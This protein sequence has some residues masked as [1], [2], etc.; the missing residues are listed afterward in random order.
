MWL[1]GPDGGAQRKGSVDLERKCSDI[2]SEIQ[3]LN[4]RQEIYQGAI[5]GNLRVQDRESKRLQD[6]IIEE[7]RDLESTQTE[8]ALQTVEKEHDLWK[9]KQTHEDARKL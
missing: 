7:I 3:R 8:E 1:A 2:S 4:K 6:Q 5:E 9:R